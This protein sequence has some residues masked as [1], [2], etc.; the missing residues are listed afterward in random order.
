[1]AVLTCVRVIHQAVQFTE[2]A[3]KLTQSDLY[4]CVTLFITVWLGIMTVSS[5]DQVQIGQPLHTRGC[6]GV[7]P[8][9][10]NMTLTCSMCV[11]RS[12]R[13]VVCMSHSLCVTW[14]VCHIAHVS[15]G[16]WSMS[17]SPCV[18]WSVCHVVHVSHGM[19]RSPCVT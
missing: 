15:H 6:R 7:Q 14:S 3:S 5:M 12:M 17:H 13:H 11:R 2:A 1:M 10:T 9:Q 8:Y 16:L 18:T 4:I 19:S